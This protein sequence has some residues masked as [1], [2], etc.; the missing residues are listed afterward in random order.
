MVQFMD[1][2]G[3]KEL[4]ISAWP[5]TELDVTLGQLGDASGI[6]DQP[7]HLEIVGVMRDDVFR[8]LFVKN[9]VH[10]TIVT[11]AED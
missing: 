7:D 2:T 4:I 9:G 6:P 11:L 3:D 8:V 5:Y 1:A 10:Y